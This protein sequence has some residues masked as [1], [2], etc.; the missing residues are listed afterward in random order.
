M[1]HRDALTAPSERQAEKRG[2]GQRAEGDGLG[3]HDG[4]G[5]VEF[6]RLGEFGEDVGPQLPI[7]PVVAD[8]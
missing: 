3:G 4:E 7:V 2:A 5:F 8:R 6:P 1:E